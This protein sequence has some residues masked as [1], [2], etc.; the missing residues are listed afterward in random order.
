M[1]KKK[2]LLSLV[3]LLLFQG[4]F[5]NSCSM[6]KNS[7]S[8]QE[9]SIPKVAN[10][11][12]I[13]T[14]VFYYAQWCGFCHRMAPHVKKAAEEF[15]GQIYFYYVDIDSEEGKAFSSKYRPN[16]RGIPFAQFYDGK[17]NYIKDKIGYID[18]AELKKSLE[19][20]TKT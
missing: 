1:I 14:Y 11:A 4:L 7:S 6:N 15:Q 16:G 8:K 12:G 3:A 2:A 20:L 5:L 17:G 18:Y 9:N 10:S 13:P 19:V